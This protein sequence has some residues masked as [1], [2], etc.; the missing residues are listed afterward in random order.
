M[1]LFYD[2]GLP[3]EVL[4]QHMI[5][6]KDVAFIPVSSCL[7]SSGVSLNEE[8]LPEEQMSDTKDVA[9]TPVSS[10]LAISGVSLGQDILEEHMS[11]IGENVSTAPISELAT[12]R[13]LDEMQIN[14]C[15][16]VD[17][18]PLDDLPMEVKVEVKDDS[19][20]NHF[21][22]QESSS[23]RVRRKHGGS[24]RSMSFPFRRWLK[25]S[26]SKKTLKERRNSTI[27]KL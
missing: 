14:G 5:D 7:A 16:S 11:V 2:A 15:D 23:G 20:M 24:G 3:E 21:S 13:P 9:V 25:P 12:L 10:C 17:H 4:E 6:T 26:H 19:H 18:E 1:L 8:D 27:R 22:A